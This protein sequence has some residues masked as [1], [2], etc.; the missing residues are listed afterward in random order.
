MR[1]VTVKVYKFDELPTDRRRK[2]PV[3][4]SAIAAT[5]MISTM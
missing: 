4:G 5:R 2:R 1:E 3:N